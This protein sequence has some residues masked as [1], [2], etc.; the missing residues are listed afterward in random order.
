MT[1]SRSDASESRTTGLTLNDLAA[2]MGPFAAEDPGEPADHMLVDEPRENPA[3]ELDF[4]EIAHNWNGSEPIEVGPE[5]DLIDLADRCDLPD[6]CDDGSGID[7]T[8]PFGFL[9]FKPGKRFRLERF[10]QIQA[11]TRGLYLIKGV[12]P[13]TGLVLIW[14]PPKEGKTFVVLDMAMHV[15][16]GWDYRGHRVKK[17]IV[18]Y[19]CLEGVKGFK[20]RIEAFRR[21]KLAGRADDA[22]NF[23]LMDTPLGLVADHRALIDAIHRQLRLYARPA[24][25]VFDTLNRSIEGSENNDEDM[26]AHIRAAEAIQ[27]CFDCAVV[28]VHHSGHGA[29][30]PRGHS[31]QLGAADVLISV[32][33]TAGLIVM[34]LERAKDDPAGLKF[35]SRL[36]SVEI[37][38][39]EDGDQ[40]TSCVV[41]AIDVATASLLPTTGEDAGGREASIADRDA[42][43]L[44]ALAENPEASLRELAAAADMPRTTAERT[45]RRLAK[46]KPALTRRAGGKWFL[47]RAG[48][49]AVKQ[50]A[51]GGTVVPFVPRDKER[52]SEP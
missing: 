27:A 22:N 12:V 25:V 31:N 46:D 36:Q 1:R 6:D 8:I 7:D 43:L 19:C 16:L 21:Y 5:L 39:D 32:K 28:I 15:A 4:T 48:E 13:S 49:E 35:F 41:E 3:P 24:E 52:E 30:R 18:D 47:A 20:R 40:V 2:Y 23:Y 29:E 33:R 51:G 14:G 38:P 17:G 37:G 42:R 45:L 26:R 10:D 11:E 44:R 34:E 9:P 50:S